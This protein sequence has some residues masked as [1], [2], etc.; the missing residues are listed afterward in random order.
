MIMPH[1]LIFQKSPRC[2]QN[3]LVSLARVVLSSLVNVI[4]CR[5]LLETKQA[6][7]EPVSAISQGEMAVSGRGE[8]AFPKQARSTDMLC[9][10][11]NATQMPASQNGNCLPQGQVS[12]VF[13]LLN[14]GRKAIVY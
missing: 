9:F 12:C 7:L 14:V 3:N 2:S 10:A 11:I 1:G 5:T 4:S 6:H 13:F 8:A